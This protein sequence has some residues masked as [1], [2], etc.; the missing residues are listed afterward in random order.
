[1]PRG[2]RTAAHLSPSD[3]PTS[4]TKRVCTTQ[5]SSPTTDV[6]Y[7]SFRDAYGLDYSRA[8][9]VGVLAYLC[10]IMR[11]P[12][13]YTIHASVLDEF[14]L[15]YSQ[16]H[17][18]SSDP[19][20]LGTSSCAIP[21]YHL[22]FA[23][24]QLPVSRQNTI[25]N[26]ADLRQIWRENVYT[27]LHTERSLLAVHKK[28]SDLQVPPPPRSPS[29][30]PATPATAQPTSHCASSSPDTDMM[31]VNLPVPSYMTPQTAIPPTEIAME[32]GIKCP[33]SNIADDLVP[34]AGSAEGLI[35][36]QV[37]QALK[38]APERHATSGCW[39]S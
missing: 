30:S 13:R 7:Q 19:R 39:P 8:Q 18:L 4:S 36:Q 12:W 28:W 25:L 24:L 9:F 10:S 21:S 2:K 35:P 14:V 33:R 31:D 1:M 5:T 37:Y 22:W 11:P 27:F 34:V 32:G 17:T 20:V 3:S 6:I 38:A 26:E 15:R 16:Y 23:H 29:V